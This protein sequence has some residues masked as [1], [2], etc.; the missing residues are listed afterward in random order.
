MCCYVTNRKH[1]VVMYVVVVV[2][3]VC[4][5]QLTQV[6]IIVHSVNSQVYNLTIITLCKASL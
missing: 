3:V 5:V 1:V 6:A 2:V 4:C